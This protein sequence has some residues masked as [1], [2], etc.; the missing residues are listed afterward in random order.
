MKHT[1][2]FVAVADGKP[3]EL[4]RAVEKSNGGVT[5]ILGHAL[6]YR[7]DVFSQDED[8]YAESRYSIHPTA[9]A[10][11]GNTL[12]RTLRTRKRTLHSYIWTEAVKKRTGFCSLFC[13]M[14]PDLKAGYDSTPRKRSVVVGEYDTSQFSLCFNVLVSAPDMKMRVISPPKVPGLFN[15]KDQTCG[16]FSAPSDFYSVD[17]AFSMFRITLLVS[18]LNAPSTDAGHLFHHQTFRSEHSAHLNEFERKL[19]GQHIN[20]FNDQ[21]AILQFTYYERPSLLNAYVTE[22][23]AAT[24]QPIKHER[25][26]FFAHPDKTSRAYKDYTSRAR[27]NEI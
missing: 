17:Y 23:Q 4:I 5:L 9:D 26:A 1:V 7:E 2:S 12:H 20:G 18:Y 14:C 19:M 22:R 27:L 25:L 8:G 11:A 3:R 13:S 6:F 10:P 15:G 16:S 24:G 21:F